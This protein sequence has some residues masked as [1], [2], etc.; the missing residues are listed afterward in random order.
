M[1][2]FIISV[3]ELNTY[4]GD[5]IYSDPF[6]D[7]LWI[8]GE[9]ADVNLNNN[10]AYFVLSD[11]YSQVNCILF[12]YAE[13]GYDLFDYEG[14][15]VLVKGKITLFKR[16]GSFKIIVDTIENYGVG[17]LY[18]NF[19]L[20]KE[21]LENE[22]IFSVEH[23]QSVP[24]FPQ[25]IGIVT[26]KDGAAIHDLTHNIFRRNPFVKI[27]LY[28]VKVQG[29]NAPFEIVRGIEYMNNTTRPDVIIVGRGGGSAEDLSA[30]NDESVVR[31]VFNSAIPIISAVGHE[32]DYT[33]TDLAA[34]LRVSTPSAAA[35]Q[36]VPLADDILNK[37]TLLKHAMNSVIMNKIRNMRE[38]IYELN[39]KLNACNPQR[40]VSTI[41]EKIYNAETKLNKIISQKYND[42]FLKYTILNEKI[43]TLNPE[44]IYQ[45]EFIK[46]L[47]DY[48]EIKSVAELKSGDLIKIIFRD[49]YVNATIN[50]ETEKTDEK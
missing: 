22:G 48:K 39:N 46:I 14:D 38:N 23:K 18:E 44:I 9:I 11:S 40:R 30:F 24:P 45:T 31:A 42:I 32:N 17:L 50:T 28:P 16:N 34:D 43:T 3:L 35:E 13:N 49:G 21:K 25:K 36:A 5:N 29:E 8:K 26:S 6:L 41:Y 20:L 4:V 12:N 7:Y 1:D 33:L 27:T 19:K 47:K 37:I 15:E 10:T 2:K